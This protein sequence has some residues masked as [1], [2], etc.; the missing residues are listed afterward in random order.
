MF[1]THVVTEVAGRWALSC[2]DDSGN[3]EG[4]GVSEAFRGTAAR[5]CSFT[6]GPA[7]NVI[8]ATQQQSVNEAIRRDNPCAFVLQQPGGSTLRRLWQAIA[9]VVH[10]W[11]HEEE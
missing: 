9:V 10:K 11:G 6:V 3:N 7:K 1:L 8:A 4:V 2:L 5:G